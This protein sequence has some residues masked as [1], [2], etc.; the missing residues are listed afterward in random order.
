MKRLVRWVKSIFIRSPKTKTQT[1][2]PEAYKKAVKAKKWEQQTMY[3]P[4]ALNPKVRGGT[5]DQRVFFSNAFVV[6]KEVI[7]SELFQDEILDFNRYTYTKDSPREIYR[8][9]MSGDDLY[10]SFKKYDR[11]MDVDVT[12]YLNRTTRTIGYTYP[13]TRRQWINSKFVKYNKLEGIK[14]IIMNVVHEYCHNMGYK[15]PRAWTKTR[16][17]S[18]PYYLG[19]A[20]G[21]VAAELMSSGEFKDELKGL[22]R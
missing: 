14:K 15:H 6:L 7:N 10:E 13:N 19:Y 3:P 22:T 21:R 1:A 16:K 5:L 8:K 17:N 12:I 4:L 9:F 2:T 20:A 18:V 11:E